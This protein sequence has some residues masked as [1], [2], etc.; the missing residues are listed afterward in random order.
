[1]GRHPILQLTPL[2]SKLFRYIRSYKQKKGMAPLHTEMG[3]HMKRSQG[4]VQSL[5]R[6]LISKGYIESDY[7]KYRGVRLLK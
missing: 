4:A 7:G 1:M 6:A 2:Q 5:L 3:K